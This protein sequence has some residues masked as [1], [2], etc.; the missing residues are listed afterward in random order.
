MKKMNEIITYR[1]AMLLKSKSTD[2]EYY[3]AEFQEH[4]KPKFT[5]EL[6]QQIDTAFIRLQQK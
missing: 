6:Q 2:K 3:M 5:P 1:R 4:K